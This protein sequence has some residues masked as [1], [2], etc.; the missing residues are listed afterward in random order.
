MNEQRYVVGN[1]ACRGQVAPPNGVD[2]DVLSS[3]HS[4]TSGLHQC[5]SF[6]SAYIWQ[7]LCLT[8]QRKAAGVVRN[9]TVEPWPNGVHFQNDVGNRS[10]GPNS[11]ALAEFGKMMKILQYDNSGNSYPPRVV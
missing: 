5:V 7:T 2:T 10:R 4:A 1:N 6:T 11:R 9:K 3:P 8:L